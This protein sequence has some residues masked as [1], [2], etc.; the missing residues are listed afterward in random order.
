[1]TADEAT[2]DY[3]IFLNRQPSAI[4]ELLPLSNE[5]ALQYFHQNVYPLG[6]IKQP[7]IVALE[8][9]SRMEVYELRYSELHQAVD[10]L[11]RLA[12]YS[13]APTL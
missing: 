2:V 9:L 5:V 7:Q 8:R 6:E 3:I 11:E 4:A 1:V 13:G 12:Q 10:R